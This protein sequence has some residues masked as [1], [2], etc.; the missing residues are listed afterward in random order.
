MPSIE[1]NHEIKSGLS[2]PPGAG[3]STFLENFGRHLTSLGKKIAVLTVDP[4]SS[5]TGGSLLGDKVPR[6]KNVL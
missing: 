5:T 2:G 1:L 6:M 4:S 3:K